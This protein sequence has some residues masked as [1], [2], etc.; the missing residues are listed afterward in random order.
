MAFDLYVI[1]DETHSRGRSHCEIARQAVDGGSCVIQ[2]RDKT[3]GSRELVRIGSEIRK[4]T[5]DAGALFIVNDRLDVALACGADGV[6]LGQGDLS[7]GTARQ[8]APP[9]SLLGFS[10][11]GA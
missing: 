10:V 9:G 6:H 11:G 8:L 4:I 1:T 5:R 3:R 2:L 7:P